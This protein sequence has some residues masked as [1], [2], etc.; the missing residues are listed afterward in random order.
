MGRRAGGLPAGG[1]APGRRAGCVF[2]SGKTKYDIK[3]FLS[4]FEFS[5]GAATFFQNK[6]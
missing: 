2:T 3:V 5:L 1:Q 6:I 4:D